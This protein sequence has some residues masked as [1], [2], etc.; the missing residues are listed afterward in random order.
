M[1]D[2]AIAR[3]ILS[4]KDQAS[5]SGGLDVMDTKD[6]IFDAGGQPCPFYNPVSSKARR[7]GS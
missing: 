7:F 5:R 1:Q 2:C 6:A 4:T 3:G